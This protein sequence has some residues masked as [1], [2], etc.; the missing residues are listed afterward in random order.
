MSFN[1]CRDVV[2]Q[3]LKRGI[4]KTTTVRRYTHLRYELTPLGTA[5]QLA[6]ARGEMR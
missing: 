6:L 3:L 5:L 1:N 2:R 4:V